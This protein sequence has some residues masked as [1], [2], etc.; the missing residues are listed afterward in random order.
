MGAYP[1]RLIVLL[2]LVYTAMLAVM[3]VIAWDPK[4]PFLGLTRDTA[5]VAAKRGKVGPVP[6]QLRTT[7]IPGGRRLPNEQ[8]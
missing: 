1:K 3:L 2:G 8:P 4:I 6:S 7:G 5:H